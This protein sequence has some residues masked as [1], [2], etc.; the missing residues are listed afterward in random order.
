[1]YFDGN[2]LIIYSGTYIFLMFL[3]EVVPCAKDSN[4]RD[5]VTN[6]QLADY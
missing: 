3:P 1:M 2:I 6:K 4:F 5:S